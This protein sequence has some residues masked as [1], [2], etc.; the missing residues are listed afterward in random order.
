LDRE[1]ALV[2]LLDLASIWLGTGVWIMFLSKQ[3]W[4]YCLLCSVLLQQPLMAQE[5]EEDDED[6]RPYDASISL[7]YVGTS[8]NTDTQTYNTEVLVEY[9]TSSWLH[10]V[11]AQ[12]LATQENNVTRAE[13]YF[14]E[15][16]SD[17]NLGDDQYWFIQGSYNDDRFSGFDFQATTATGYGRFLSNTDRFRLQLYGGAGYRENKRLN[18]PSDG[19]AIVSL[20]QN[21][22]WRLNSTATITQ[23]FTSEIGDD[24]TVSRFELALVSNILGRVATRIAFQARNNSSPPLGATSTDTQTSVSL[25]YTF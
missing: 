2:F 8:G 11:K 20:G 17:Y 7:G 4:L 16:K 13:R 15:N 22:R 6:G 5:E 12:G 10:N 25:V 14:F 3:R 23:S 1:Q 19:Q 9:R 21:L 24:L 18:L